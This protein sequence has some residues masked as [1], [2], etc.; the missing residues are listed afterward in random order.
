MHY[1]TGIGLAKPPTLTKGRFQQE[2]TMHEKHYIG[3]AASTQV[4]HVF[5]LGAALECDNHLTHERRYRMTLFNVKVRL[6]SGIHCGGEPHPKAYVF[7][8]S[9]RISISHSTAIPDKI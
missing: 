8:I 3:F 7:F 6:S 9:A 5:N 2:S 4:L 1:G